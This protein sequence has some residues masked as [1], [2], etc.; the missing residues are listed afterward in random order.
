MLGLL[1][2]NARLRD[3]YCAV[4]GRYEV[5]KYSTGVGRAFGDAMVDTNRLLRQRI[6]HEKQLF[7]TLQ[8]GSLKENRC[9][10]VR[11]DLRDSWIT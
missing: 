1:E 4:L 11:M 2:E 3:Y 10:K 6:D 9:Q 8:E 7:A 5:E